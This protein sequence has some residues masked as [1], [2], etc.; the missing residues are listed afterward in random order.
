MGSMRI[1]FFKVRCI[2]QKFG[3][4]PCILSILC[5]I[6]CIVEKIGLTNFNGL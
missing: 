6:I 1:N 4:S 3:Y 5:F 2:L